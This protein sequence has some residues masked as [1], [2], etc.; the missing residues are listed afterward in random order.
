MTELI[1]ACK[2]GDINKVKELLENSGVDINHQNII[3]GSTA[4]MFASC[5]GYKE[6]VKLLLN[7]EKVIVN[8]NIQN[9]WGEDTLMWASRNGNIDIIKLLLNYK[10]VI[11][12]PNVKNKWGQ[13]ALWF[14]FDNGHLKVVKL[15]ENYIF[16]K[17]NIKTF[18]PSYN[19]L[20][21]ILIENRY[22]FTYTNKC[23]FNIPNEII[24]LIK[25]Y[26]EE[27]CGRELFR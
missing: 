15:L 1:H 11:V 5:N 22:T 24:L 3:I 21:F 2:K 12:N 16:Y 4:V 7:Y 18:I 17:E 6:I 19:I 27:V 26:G 13:D 23:R 10:K 20:L 8:P 9:V 14:A 25:E